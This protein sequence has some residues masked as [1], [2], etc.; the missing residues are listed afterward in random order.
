M[1]SIS[2][3]SAEYIRLVPAGRGCSGA[4]GT[5]AAVVMGRLLLYLFFHQQTLL[6]PPLFDTP[7]QPVSWRHGTLSIAY[8]CPGV[9]LPVGPR[10]VKRQRYSVSANPTP[11]TRLPLGRPSPLF[12]PFPGAAPPSAIHRDSAGTSSTRGSHKEGISHNGGNSGEPLVDLL[13]HCVKFVLT[14]R[15]ARGCH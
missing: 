3:I 11:K 7:R 9:S 12:L 5:A 13:H 10:R 2:Y 1:G 15:R 4:D 14:L 6:M 8:S